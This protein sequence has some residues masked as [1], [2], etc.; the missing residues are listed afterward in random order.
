MTYI[1]TY[2][3][4]ILGLL[5]GLTALVGINIKNLK[6]DAGISALVAEDHPDYVYSQEMK[7]IFGVTDQV[8]V[9]VTAKESVY[10][11]DTLAFIHELTQFFENLEEID[12]DDV[13]SLTNVNDIQGEDGELLVDPLVDT[14]ALDEFDQAALDSIREHVRA[15]PMYAGK[16]VSA[17]ERSAVVI[18]GVAEEISMKDEAVATLKAKILNKLDEL[19]LKYP[20][21]TVNFSGPAMLKAFIS[22]Y[23][24]KDMQQLFPFAILIVTLTLFF[25]LRSVFG[26][27]A[28]I[29]VTLFSIVWTLG[30]KGFLNSPLTIV[31]TAIPVILIA[32]GC[33]DGIHIISEFFRFYRKGHTVNDA[34]RETMRLLTLPVILTSV[35]TGLG[36]VSL[37][38]APGVSIRNMG[39][40]LAFGVMVA[41]V[42]SLLFI[43]S[44]ITF[45]RTRKDLTYLRQPE[46]LRQPELYAPVRSSST[47]HT[48]AEQIGTRIINHRYLISAIALVVL[49]ISILGIINIQVESDE[50][51]YFKKKNVFRR[52]TE[53]IQRDLGGI[54]SLDII[55]EGQ[56]A[57]TLKHPGLLKKIEELQR[58][59]EQDELVSYTL[60][61]ADLVKRIN[62][63]LHDNDPRYDRLPEEVETVRYEEYVDVDGKDVL[64]EKTEEVSGYDQV[65]QFLLLYDMSGGEATDQYVDDE[66]RIGR[67]IVRLK[68]MSSQRLNRLLAK[69]KPYIAA[70]LSDTVTVRYT[71]HYIRVVMMDLI[72]DSQIYSLL[73]V[74]LTITILMSVIF[75]SPV[76]GL[77]TSLPVFIAVLFNFAVMW[78]F[79]VTLNV[80]T[81]IIA[82]VGMGVGIDY[83]I[84]YFSRFRFILRE[85]G[86]YEMALIKAIMETSR[87]ILSNASAV[88]LG[89]LVLLLSEY[90]VIGNVGW[91]T[92]L[93]MVT[94]ALSSLVVLPAI[95][96][97]VR[98]KVK[99]GKQRFGEYVKN[100]SI[101]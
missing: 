85:T 36:F 16:L 43:P 61:V 23:M 93:S 5:L 101:A 62:Y 8:V 21:V 76:V 31:E 99:W 15:N 45:Y 63:A 40:F 55:I 82:S 30:L 13:I 32:I 51:R 38:T 95:L 26:M 41:M 24:Q 60:S 56:E 39:V 3:W 29:L 37:V 46:V 88:G 33:A 89:F 75:R 48:I 35:T 25:L 80:G 47:F 72:I 77:I 58:I 1:R 100:P 69:I 68:D 91:I 2:R 49:I 87:P 22:E 83:A 74:L 9:G 86:D 14:D 11:P 65:A 70:N 53:N 79:G 73:T 19:Q 44:L 59:C 54:T 28:P 12:E 66:Y 10:T 6:R 7:E 34:L 71:N 27:L 42:F 94:T 17:D 4:L 81:S 18:A 96:S 98:P 84:H 90:Q 97:I 92:A 50:V 64:V 20:E 57:D 67:I 52:A 78:I